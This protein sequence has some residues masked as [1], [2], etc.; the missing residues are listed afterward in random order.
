MSPEL[1]VGSVGSVGSAWA[2]PVSVPSTADIQAAYAATLVD[3][4]ARNGVRH[5]VVCPGS[6]S[7]PLALALA[8]DP[9]V[10]VHVRLDERSAGFT[11]VGIGLATGVP[12]VVL[13]TSGTAAAELHAAISNLERSGEEQAVINE[14]ALSVNE[15][16][17]STNEELVTSKEELQALNEELVALNGQLQDTLEKQEE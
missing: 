1:P 14:E 5:A 10:T 9:H 4:W 8:A 6:R 11:G 3:E 16:Y 17:Q 2:A 15:E 7:T 13:T 12:A